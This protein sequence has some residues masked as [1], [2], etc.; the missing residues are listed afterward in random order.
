MG[1]ITVHGQFTAATVLL[2]LDP[3]DLTRSTVA[4][5]IEA[6][7]VRTGDDRRDADLRSA[8]FLDADVF[9]T[10]VFASTAIERLA[11]DRFRVDGELTIRD[12]TRSISLELVGT[13]PVSDGRG[14]LRRGFTATGQIDRTAW[15]L[16]WNMALETGG[17]L[18]SE[19]V[20][21]ELEVA[22][23]GPAGDTKKS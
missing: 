6:N 11:A 5:R 22:V 8:H 17:W 2:N 3:R 16:N 1:I 4:A 20:Q 14:G 9:P 18:V 23:F 21:L 12:V 15:G 7:S 10:I 13:A 19:E